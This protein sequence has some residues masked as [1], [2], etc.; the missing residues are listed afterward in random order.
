MPLSS[1]GETIKAALEKEYGKEKGERVLYAGKNKGTFTGIDD[2]TIPAGLDA[3][4]YKAMC[5]VAS[6]MCDEVKRLQVRIDDFCTKRTDRLLRG[7]GGAIE[8]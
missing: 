8:K 4:V 7:K 1:K 6:A 2:N 3:D 5:D